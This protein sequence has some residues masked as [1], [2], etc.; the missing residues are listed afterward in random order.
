MPNYLYGSRLHGPRR[1]AGGARATWRAPGPSLIVV[2]ERRRAGKTGLL[3]RFVEG[4][5]AIDHGAT[6]EAS[7]VELRRLSD[8]ARAVLR[9]E[10]G[11]LLAHGDFTDW[12]TALSYLGQ[13]ARGRRL[14]VV[15]D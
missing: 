1:R 5:R 7:G 12:P 15:L 14:A 9:P 4:K 3:G 13:R 11:D 2:W 8:A 6:E 10:P